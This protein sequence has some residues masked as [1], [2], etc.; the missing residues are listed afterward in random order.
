MK[1]E[2]LHIERNLKKEIR[3]IGFDDGPFK[4]FN[5][6]KSALAV[7]V[8]FRGGLYFEGMLKTRISIDGFNSTKKIVEAIKGS[9]FYPQLKA[10]LFDGISLGGFNVI[11]VEELYSKTGIPVIIIMRK[12]PNFREMFE[13][14]MHTSKP[15]LRIKAI[16]KAGK[17]K[18][19]RVEN[20]NIS[21]FV[22]YQKQGCSEDYAEK[23][24]KL[25][26]T[27]ALIPEPLRIAHLIASAI[28]EGESRGRA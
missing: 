10:I 14:V 13:A 24:I 15:E 16:K 6:K 9:K 3:V 21:G 23:I 2:A 11:D 22:Y 12:I 18:K 4:K 7:G 17:I 20:T 1:H 28:V 25:T 5:K 26:T 19:V 8:I 27:R